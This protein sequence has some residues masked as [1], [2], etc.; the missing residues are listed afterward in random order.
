MRTE[1]TQYHAHLLLVE[2]AAVGEAREKNNI[3]L[4]GLGQVLRVG[5]TGAPVRLDEYRVR[6]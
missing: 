4:S 3:I 1:H 2:A 5:S 6:C